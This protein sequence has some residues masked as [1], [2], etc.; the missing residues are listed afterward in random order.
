MLNVVTNPLQGH[1]KVTETNIGRRGWVARESESVD[2]VAILQLV[3]D[4]SMPN[5]GAFSFHRDNDNVAFVSNELP[6]GP[7]DAA[8]LE[9]P[10]TRLS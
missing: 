5:F 2:T 1:S 3:H 7:R 9:L 4:I 6:R 10:G 8:C